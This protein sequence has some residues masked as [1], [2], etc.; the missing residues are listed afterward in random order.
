MKV[1]LAG[2]MRGVP[3]FNAPAFAYW[4]EHLRR[5]GHEVYSPSEMSDKL[6][7]AAVRENAEGD[8]ARMGGDALTIGRTVFHLDMAFICLHADAVA[9]LPGWQTSK[10]ATA[11]YAAAVALGL[12]IIF[13]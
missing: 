3:A 4:T 11:E 8:E 5:A 7:G 2:K 13:L 12:Q 9:L 1:Y 6:F 10:G